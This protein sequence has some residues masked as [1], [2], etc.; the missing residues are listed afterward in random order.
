MRAP[1]AGAAADE[2]SRP[3]RAADVARAD[4]RAL[5]PNQ[6]SIYPELA[7]VKR[8]FAR[9]APSPESVNPGRRHINKD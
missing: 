1:V 3:W 5:L 6:R 2:W 9:R 8:I 4:D 7:Q